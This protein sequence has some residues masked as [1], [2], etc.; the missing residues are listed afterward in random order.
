MHASLS[1]SRRWHTDSIEL[2]EKEPR[3]SPTHL[4]AAHLWP[5]GLSLR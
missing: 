4:Q 1:P 5:T 3:L 2:V